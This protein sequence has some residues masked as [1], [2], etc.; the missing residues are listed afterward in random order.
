MTVAELELV[1]RDQ[2]RII[3]ALTRE[4]KQVLVARKLVSYESRRKMSRARMALPLEV[5]QESSRKGGIARSRKLQQTRQVQ[6]NGSCHT[7]DGHANG[8]Q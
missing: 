7:D 5:R 3:E 2:D 1:I 6:S 4:L 8:A